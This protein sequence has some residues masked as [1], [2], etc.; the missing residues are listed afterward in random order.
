MKKFLFLCCALPLLLAGSDYSNYGRI[1]SDSGITEAFWTMAPVRKTLELAFDPKLIKKA[2]L[3]YEIFIPPVDSKRRIKVTSADYNWKNILVTVNRKV[4]YRGKPGKLI[5]QG[6]HTIDFPAAYLQ[7]G[8]NVITFAWDNKDKTPGAARGYI[9]MAADK[10]P[11]AKT[12]TLPPG[13][14]GKPRTRRVV[15]N[16]NIRMRFLINML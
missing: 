12:I 9:Y 8:V 6:T 15:P 7:Q 3:E 10:N 14:N 16:D 13:K 4:I 1:M 2:A 11:P 5:L